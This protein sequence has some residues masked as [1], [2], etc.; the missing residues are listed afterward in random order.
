[1]TEKDK[2]AIFETFKVS[3]IIEDN[4]ERFENR[5]V[6]LQAFVNAKKQNRLKK[7]NE[8]I[9][10]EAEDEQNVEDIKLRGLD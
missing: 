9:S 8:I 6:S 2:E 1:M 4:P 5:M 10:L 3:Q 7:I